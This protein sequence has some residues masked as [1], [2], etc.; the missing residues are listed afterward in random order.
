MYELRRIAFYPA[1][2]M[3]HT[4]NELRHGTLHF[5]LPRK[6]TKQIQLLAMN[7]FR[8]IVFGFTLQMRQS[9]FNLRQQMNCNAFLS[10]P[11]KFKPQLYLYH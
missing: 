3:R 5:A 8:H 1:N 2:D 7:E 4:L 10:L 6:W 9:R 11:Q